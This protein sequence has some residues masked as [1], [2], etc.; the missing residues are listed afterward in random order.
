IICYLYMKSNGKTA[1]DKAQA[2]PA[3]IFHG[4]IDGIS[5]TKGKLTSVVMS[6]SS[7]GGG[8]R[9]GGGGHSGGG[10]GHRF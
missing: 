2:K 3:P 6:S 9:G 1:D 7:G 4:T 5:V 8:S 10:G